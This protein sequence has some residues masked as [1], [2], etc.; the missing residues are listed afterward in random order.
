V[1]LACLIAGLVVVPVPVQDPPERL[2]A[3]CTDAKFVVAATK[4]WLFSPVQI[5]HSPRGMARLR[6]PQP[7][8]PPIPLES[9]I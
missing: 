6:A 1:E 7:P 4:K 8:P 9:D 2:V 5:I 3:L